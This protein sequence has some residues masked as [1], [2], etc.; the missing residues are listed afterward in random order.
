MEVVG[1]TEEH[2]IELIVNLL[3]ENSQLGSYNPETK[4]YKKS[5][6]ARVSAY[7]E[8]ALKALNEEMKD[9]ES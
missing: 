2:A 3:N 1:I 9:E 7:L 8:K 5:K 6:Q 4:I